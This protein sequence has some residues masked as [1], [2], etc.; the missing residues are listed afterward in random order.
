MA[1]D[2]TSYVLGKKAGG[3]PAPTPTYQDKEITI[4]QNGE[5]T[6]TADSGYDALSSVE[7]TT[8]VPQPSGKI[9]ITENGNNIDVSSY[10]TADVN[11][12][13]DISEY[14]KTTLTSNVDNWESILKKYPE[15]SIN[16]TSMQL[17][18][19][20]WK[21]NMQPPK[22]SDT[23]NITDFRDAFNEV[24]LSTI[25]TVEDF[26]ISSATDMRY[27]FANCYNLKTLDLSNW[28]NLNYIQTN[29]M[30][31]TC[32]QLEELDMSNFDFTMTYSTDNMFNLVPA[33]CLIYVKDQTQVDW[34]TTN[35]PSLT[36]VQIKGA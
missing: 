25:K 36:N 9:T 1:I 13:A 27:M 20:K 30:F 17:M 29:N 24:L 31:D 11:V 12:S 32:Y 34:F 19:K 35:F 6:I 33:N 10:A 23:S 28:V 7:I 26:D 2:I 4:T 22:I 14:F 16:G 18:F 3:G 8:N 15:I 5:Q 21:S